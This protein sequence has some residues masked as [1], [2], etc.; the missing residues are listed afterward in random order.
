MLLYHC[1]VYVYWIHKI[2]HTAAR[3]STAIT[4]QVPIPLTVRGHLDIASSTASTC[5]SLCCV[6]I[7]R[8]ARSLLLSGETWVL[9]FVMHFF[10]GSLRKVLWP[11]LWSSGE[12]SWLQNKGSWVL[13][14]AVWDFL[15]SSSWSETAFTQPRE[16][17]WGATGV[18]K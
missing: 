5:V 10:L 6:F 2:S 4:V 12:S 15:R 9:S 8:T 11:P 3:V 7:I 13:F 16:D 17:N 14:V 18:E 1:H